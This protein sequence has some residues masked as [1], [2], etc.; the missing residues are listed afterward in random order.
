VDESVVT[1]KGVLIEGTAAA[2]LANRTR[3]RRNTKPS[4]GEWNEQ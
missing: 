3:L 1:E 4:E 2:I